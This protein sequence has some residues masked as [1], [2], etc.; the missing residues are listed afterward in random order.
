MYME[1]PTVYSEIFARISFSRIT[2][3]CLPRKSIGHYL[4][5]SVNDILRGFYFHESFAKINQSRNFPNLQY[6]FHLCS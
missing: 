2:L 6:I 5:T 4:P 1:T 3:T